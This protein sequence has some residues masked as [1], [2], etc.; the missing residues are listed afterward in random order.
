MRLISGDEVW[1]EEQWGIV[2]TLQSTLNI[3]F[4][5][6]FQ[7]LLKYNQGENTQTGLLRFTVTMK[8]GLMYEFVH[9][10]PIL[11]KY[12]LMRRACRPAPSLTAL[13]EVQRNDKL[14]IREDIS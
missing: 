2:L 10:N 1:Y 3:D 12:Y 7:G 11:I 13:P 5:D 6:I 8:K 9:N 4:T 14:S